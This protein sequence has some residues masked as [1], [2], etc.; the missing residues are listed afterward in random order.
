M[1]SNA[2]LKI[3]RASKKRKACKTCKG[4]AGRKRKAER[5]I[6]RKFKEQQSMEKSMD[7]KRTVKPAEGNCS[8]QT[9]KHESLILAQ[10]E[11]WRRA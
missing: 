10:D 8:R 7:P 3:P 5:K 11:R 6:Q 4:R 1:N 9:N 2:A